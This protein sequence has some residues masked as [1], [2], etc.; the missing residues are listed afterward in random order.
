MTKQEI[1]C[2]YETMCNPYSYYEVY[3]GAETPTGH[4]R[5]LGATPIYEQ[6]EAAVRNAKTSGK[7]CFIKGVKPDG[8]KVYFL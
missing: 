4:G 8:T 1:L 2:K 7:V 5:Y 3:E 6:A